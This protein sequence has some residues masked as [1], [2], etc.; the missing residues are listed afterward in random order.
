MTTLLGARQNRRQ[1]GRHIGAA[2]EQRFIVVRPKWT[3]VFGAD[4]GPAAN[5]LDG[6][7][8]DAFET[9][10]LRSRR[11]SDGSET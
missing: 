6:S 9:A 7:R 2:V 3:L 8:H 4:A 5:G 11:S 10:G 1:L